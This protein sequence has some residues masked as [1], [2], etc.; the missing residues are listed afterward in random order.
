M[1]TAIAAQRL[2]NQCITR[3]GSHAPADVVAWLGA[4]QS[5]EFPAARWGL[6]LRMAE[7][8][9]DREVERAFDEGR[10]LRTHVMR[11]TWHF[12]TPSD[13]RWI[14][15]LT[16]PRVHRAMAHYRRRHGLETT[17]LTRAAAI[18]ERALRDGRYL[19]RPELG[20]QLGRDGR[21]RTVP[22]VAKG[23]PLALL[24]IYA[25]LEGI[26]CS[27]PSRGKQPTYALLAG[28]APGAMRLSRD[29]A[30]A[31]LTRRYF[32]SH[33]PATIRDFVWWSGLTSADAKRGLEMTRAWHD[34]IDGRTYWNLGQTKARAGTRH[35]PVHLLPVYDEYLVA[36][37]DREAVPHGPPVIKSPSGERVTF[38]HALVIAGQVAGTWRTVRKA[39]ELIVEITP[40]RRLTRPERRAL[41]ETAAHYGRFLDAPVSVAIADL[42]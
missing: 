27:G 7:G 5:Q 37:R 14:L 38:Q 34:I 15:D 24:T 29:E 10:I 13:I 1:N 31:E 21:L 25:E 6:G 33:G 18:F 40:V 19:T 20:L 30:L 42:P 26:V 8:T 16:A 23:I 12:V 39:S 11:P 9:T 17:I 41:D 35:R 4:V 2:Q 22:G 36:Y 32:T 3:A 28:R